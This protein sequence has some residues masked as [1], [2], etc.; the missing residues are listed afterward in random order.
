MSN[1][2]DFKKRSKSSI[3]DLT[4]KIEDL[5]KEASFKDDRFWKPEVD[6][7]G[8]GYAVIRFLPSA[9]GEDIPWAK[10]Y[11]HA[12][13]SKGGWLIENC[14][15]TIGQKCPICEAN[16]ELWNSGI[17]KDKDIAR[18]RKRKL[19]YISNILVISDPANPANDGKMFL[20][21][22][23]TKIFGKIQEAMQPQFKDEEAINPF[24]FWKGA[25]FKLKIRKV[26]GYTNYD[27]SEFDGASEL[28]KGDDEKL[29]SLWKSLHKLNE[30][31]IPTEFKS[32][33][34]LK[35]KMNDVLGGDLRDIGAQ[36]K[37]I[38][39]ED[40]PSTPKRSGPSES[41]DAMTYFERLSREN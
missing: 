21:K 22:Y 19:S 1:F 25:N 7:A 3:E 28:Y 23:G 41:E 5:N 17:E 13:Q 2:S 37:T 20:F 34:E 36:S 38:E 10:V 27:K 26:A 11:S 30:F 15:T 33:D 14:P 35:K 9:P 18:N 4:K 31:V 40:T 8:N 16:S 6:K 29:E 24:D 39:D 12:F 32:Y